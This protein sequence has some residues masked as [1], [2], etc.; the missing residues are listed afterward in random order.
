MGKPV[1]KDLYGI[2]LSPLSFRNK[3]YAHDEELMAEKDAGLLAIYHQDGSVVSSEYILRCKRHLEKTIEKCVSDNTIGKIYKIS[4]DDNLV[5][6]ITGTLNLFTNTLEY[7][8]NEAPYTFIRFHLEYDLFKKADNAIL[9]IDDINIKINFT[10]SVNQEKKSFA[11]NEK[12]VNLNDMAYAMDYDWYEEIDGPEEYKIT[13][14]SFT[15]EVPD[16][17]DESK[18]GF[19]LYDILLIMQ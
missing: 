12:L 8:N 13:I 3:K 4:P 10:L 9:D 18:I 7:T 19:V 6:T 2:G 5:K 16:D 1:L 11:I 17:F 15:V 14:N